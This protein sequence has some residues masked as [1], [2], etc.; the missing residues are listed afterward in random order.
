MV[1]L[2]GCIARQTD[3]EGGKPADR[4]KEGQTERQTDRH[5]FV[6][7]SSLLHVVCHWFSVLCVCMYWI[8]LQYNVTRALVRET[9]LKLWMPKIIDKQGKPKVG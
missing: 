6:C 4:P 5:V 2:N 1:C 8:H 9:D 3:N 7:H